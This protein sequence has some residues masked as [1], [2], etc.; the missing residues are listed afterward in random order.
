MVNGFYD[1]LTAEQVTTFY[2]I[3][4]FLRRL[5]VIG[6]FHTK[7]VQ[8]TSEI[9]VLGIYDIIDMT[10]AIYGIK[11]VGYDKTKGL[12][13][14]EELLEKMFGRINTPLRGTP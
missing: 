4:K 14:S 9:D 8:A 1:K 12:M 7:T 13:D 6:T 3:V 5:R 2:N 11:K 10:D